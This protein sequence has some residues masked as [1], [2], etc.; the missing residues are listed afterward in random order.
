MSKPISISQAA[1]EFNE[2]WQSDLNYPHGFSE[3][4]IAEAEQSLK[5]LWLWDGDRDLA[6]L[7]Q[8]GGTDFKRLLYIALLPKL[9]EVCLQIEQT[10][11]GKIYISSMLATLEQ[12]GLAQAIEQEIE[13]LQTDT[14]REL[15]AVASDQTMNKYLNFD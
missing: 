11:K 1:K 8:A 4:L 3:E 15:I 2:T 10:P 6:S 9:L 12:T 14:G 7:Q 5:A 13:Q